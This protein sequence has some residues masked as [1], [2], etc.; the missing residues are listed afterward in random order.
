[1]A[2]DKQIL[3]VI[4][5]EDRM[6][7]TFRR[8]QTQE[9]QKARSLLA[10]ASSHFDAFGIMKKIVEDQTDLSKKINGYGSRNRK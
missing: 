5:K 1:M 9:A 10:M 7:E 2:P 8:L 4:S 3:G 6:Q